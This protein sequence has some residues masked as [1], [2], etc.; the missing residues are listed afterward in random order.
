MMNNMRMN[1]R[2][3]KSGRIRMNTIRKIVGIFSL[4]RLVYMWGCNG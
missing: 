3:S 1:M 2:G 4:N